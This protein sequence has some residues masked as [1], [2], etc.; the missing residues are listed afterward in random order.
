MRDK[1]IT[2]TQ[3][4][5]VL[6]F[7]SDYTPCTDQ[8]VVTSNPLLLPSVEFEVSPLL[9]MVL[10]HARNPSFFAR[11]LLAKRTIVVFKGYVL[12]SS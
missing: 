10:G 6:P 1:S 3:V 8:F 2:L 7:L 11:I 5:L 9:D 4:P 12:V